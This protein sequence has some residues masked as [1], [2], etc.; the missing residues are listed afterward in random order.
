[1]ILIEPGAYFRIFKLQS[2]AVH[3]ISCNE[4]VADTVCRMTW[5]VSVG[6]Y[7]LDSGRKYLFIAEC[8]YL[9]VIQ[10]Q[11]F[12]KSCSLLFRHSHPCIVFLLRDHHHGIPEGRPFGAGLSPVCKSAEMVSMKMGDEH[13]VYIVRSDFQFV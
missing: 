9:A 10:C 4:Q 8:P 3:H 13:I 6:S 5:C 11:D 2:Y 1:M 12:T 7:S